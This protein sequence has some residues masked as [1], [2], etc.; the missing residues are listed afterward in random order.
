[1]KSSKFISKK[2]GNKKNNYLAVDENFND[3]SNQLSKLGLELRDITGDGNCC[4]RALSDQMQ[5]NESHHLEYRKRVC[6]YMKQNKEE[7]EPFVAALFDEDDDDQF[8]KLS[9]IKKLDSFE[10]Y[11]KNMEQP[12]TYADNGCLVAFA[13]LYQ[14]NINIHQLNLPIWTINGVINAKKTKCSRTTSFIS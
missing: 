10:K 8:K 14:V 4:F 5:G 3:F 9:N 2:N 13:R 12:G 7:F 6:Q 1:M 11:I